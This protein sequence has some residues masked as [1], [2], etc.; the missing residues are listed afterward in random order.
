MDSRAGDEADFVFDRAEAARAAVCLVMTSYYEQIQGG[1][2]TIRRFVA[3][4]N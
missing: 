1:M 2:I 3:S 4:G